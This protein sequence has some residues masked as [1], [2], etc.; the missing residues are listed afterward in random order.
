MLLFSLLYMLC[1]PIA[2]LQESDSVSHPLPKGC[3]NY[4]YIQPACLSV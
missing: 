4:W 3:H 2:A 1:T